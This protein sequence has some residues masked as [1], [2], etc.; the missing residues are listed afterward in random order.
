M[1]DLRALEAH[2]AG[3]GSRTCYEA[4]TVDGHGRALGVYAAPGIAPG[5]LLQEVEAPVTTFIKANVTAA[6]YGD[7]V[8]GADLTIK[9]NPSR[10]ANG[11]VRSRS[12]TG[13]LVGSTSGPIRTRSSADHQHDPADPMLCTNSRPSCT[14]TFS[15]TS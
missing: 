12:T 5:P 11:H 10:A 8:V 3:Q 1:P 13:S 14:T 15:A 7:T 6:G 2:V 9:P 4:T